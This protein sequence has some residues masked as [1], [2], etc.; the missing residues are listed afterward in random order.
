MP[1]TDESDSE[2]KSDFAQLPCNCVDEYRRVIRFRQALFDAFNEQS[3]IS[4]GQAIAMFITFYIDATEGVMKLLG[5]DPKIG[6]LERP[7]ADFLWKSLGRLQLKPSRGRPGR[8]DKLVLLLYA[9]ALSFCPNAYVHL[10]RDALTLRKQQ[11][12]LGTS[13]ATSHREQWKRFW[14]A[15]RAAEVSPRTMA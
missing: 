5:K 10:L 3:K 9:Y 7:N 6:K 14:K 15:K 13:H 1:N 12:S 4:D 11:Y 8:S 2:P